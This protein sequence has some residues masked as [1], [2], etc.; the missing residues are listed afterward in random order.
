MN[1]RLAEFLISL[2]RDPK[3]LSTF[4]DPDYGRE[5]LLREADLPEEDKEALRSEDAS[6]VLRRLQAS[7]EDGLSWVMAPG[8]KK[9]TVGF[10][11]GGASQPLAMDA[12]G[13]KAFDAE[14]INAVNAPGIKAMNVESDAVQPAR[15]KAV[16]GKKKT[17]AGKKKTAAG[18][19]K[20]TRGG[21][22]RPAK[23]GS[24]R[25]SAARGSASKSRR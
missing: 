25:S 4:N 1:T 9:F 2:V 10:T 14:G 3:R 16:A 5:A 22:A 20:Q 7:D 17:A 19:K 8:I 12:P 15:K 23:R 21:A 11:I 18:G 24:A 13:I 6:E